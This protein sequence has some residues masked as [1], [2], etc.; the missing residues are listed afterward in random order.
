MIAQYFLSWF[1]IPLNDPR[2]APSLV[3]LDFS[4]LSSFALMELLAFLKLDVMRLFER[5]SAA[6]QYRV[7]GIPFCG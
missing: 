2:D 3:W 5:S 7:P 6:R 4:G 1:P